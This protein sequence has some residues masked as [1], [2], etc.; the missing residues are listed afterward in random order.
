MQ[1]IYSTD[2]IRVVASG[3]D[4]PECVAWGKDGFLYAGG[5]AGQI[6]RID[7]AGGK[8]GQIAS[9]AGFLLGI[10]LDGANNVYACDIANRDV[11]RVTPDGQVAIYS[12]G[13][14]TRPM[15]C[16]N[17]PAFDPR[18]NLYVSDSGAW[19]ANNSC[20]FRMRPGG[21]TEVWSSEP[22]EFANGLALHPS[23]KYLYVAVSLMPGVARLE[24]REDDS[25]GPPEKV[26]TIAETVPD[27][28]AFD[29]QGN[30]YVS[31]YRPDRIYVFTAAGELK[32]VADDWMGTDLAAPTNIAFYGENLEHMAIASLGRW[33]ISALPMEIRGSPLNYPK[34]P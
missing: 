28:L 3:L 30:L 8:Y 34:I 25:A 33:S 18:G 1:P 13:T 22:K 2:Q 14:S 29:V 19:K 24:I 11:R 31:C 23:G 12:S 7:P 26:V 5:E 17:Y 6:Y 32:L 27:G 10:A 16:P 15:H 21:H 9:T 20:I 4:H